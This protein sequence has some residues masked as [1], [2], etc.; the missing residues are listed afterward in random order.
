MVSHG[1]RTWTADAMAGEL[2]FRIVDLSAFI[3]STSGAPSNEQVEALFHRVL[4]VPG[5]R[6]CPNGKMSSLGYGLF[7]RL[8]SGLAPSQDDRLRRTHGNAVEYRG[9]RVPAA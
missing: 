6:A 9:C 4:H 7:S 2:L 1:G 8:A 5:R 3:E